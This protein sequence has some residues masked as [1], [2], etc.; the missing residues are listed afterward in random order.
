M[1]TPVRRRQLE[2]LVLHHRR[3]PT[4]HPRRLVSRTSRWKEP[5]AIG[6]CRWCYERTASPRTRWHLYCL[7]AY[8]VASGQH[9]D[10]IQRTLCEICGAPPDEIDHRLAIEV[11]RAL[12]PAAM[13]RA[14][15]LDNLRWLCRSC[16]RRKT[17]QDRRLVKFL[18]ACSLDWHSARRMLRQHHD[19]LQSF[20]LPRSLESAPRQSG[21]S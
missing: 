20:L 21:A 17:R 2:G 11:A 15:T 19:W 14:F 13:L 16:H 4:E 1:Q 5:T 18:V 9:P 7:N 12:G 10:E 8:R 3:H 6:I